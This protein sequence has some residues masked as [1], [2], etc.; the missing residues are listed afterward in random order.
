MCVQSRIVGSKQKQLAESQKWMIFSLKDPAH[1]KQKKF[2][3]HWTPL[4]A[5]L[6]GP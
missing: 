6:G 3:P 5:D 4:G 1:A 2:E